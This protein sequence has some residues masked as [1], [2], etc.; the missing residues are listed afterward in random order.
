MILPGIVVKRRRD[1]FLIFSSGLEFWEHFRKLPEIA[2]PLPCQGRGRGF[3]SLRP[4]QISHVV[5]PETWVRNVPMTGDNPV[6]NGSR[7]C[8]VSCS[9]SK[10]PGVRQAR[11]PDSAVFLLAAVRR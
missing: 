1:L 2:C 8:E 3:E 10:Y 6:P 7:G 4:L 11:E 9:R 5:R